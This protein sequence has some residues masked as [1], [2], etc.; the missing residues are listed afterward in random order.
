MPKLKNSNGTFWFFSNFKKLCSFF[1]F[2]N[3]FCGQSK[4]YVAWIDYLDFLICFQG[5]EWHENISWSAWG[6]LNISICVWN[7]N[8]SEKSVWHNLDLDSWGIFSDNWLIFPSSRSRLLYSLG[9]EL[10]AKLP[11]SS[12]SSKT[13]HNCLYADIVHTARWHTLLFTASVKIII[14]KSSFEL[15]VKNY[16]NMKKSIYIW[17]FPPK[18]NLKWLKMLHLIFFQFDIFHQFLSY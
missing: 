1:Y 13:V 4:S 17:I 18:M 2:S 5:G 3:S 7:L 14:K 6:C 9:P 15:T 16:Q 8:R 10:F 11:L 12:S